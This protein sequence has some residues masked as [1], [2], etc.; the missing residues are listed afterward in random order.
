MRLG[1][2]CNFSHKHIGGSEAVLKYIS[3][4]LVKSYNYEV[5]VYSYSVQ[6][7]F[8]ENGVKYTSC[9]KGNDLITQINEND[10]IYVYSDSFWGWDT[11]VESIDKVAPAVSVALVG[12]YHMQSH[13]EIFNLL[14][15]NIDKFNLITHS[16]ITP[17]YKWCIDKGLPVKVI[18]NG[19]NIE[20]F[21]QNTINFREKYNIKEKY[22]ILNVGNYFYGKGF[23]LLPKICN[24]ISTFMHDFIILQI[25]NTVKYSYDKI[26]FERTKKQSGGMNIRFFRDISRED[27]IAAF[28]NADTFLFTSKKEVAP[29]VILE[30]IAAETPWL[31][32]DVGNIGEQKGGIILENEN[33]DRKGYKVVNDILLGK[34]AAN[35]G[36]IVRNKRTNKDLTDECRENIEKIDWDNIVPLYHEVFSK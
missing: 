32:M 22:V 18:P 9:K 27:V 23:E 34:Y 13:S 2:F 17:D 16:A 33:K 19:V 12:A 31:S 14:K 21:E 35:V 28:K 25:S 11:I 3:E 29:L 10:H 36:N 1:I 8:S 26:F 15:E 30:S 20:E 7:P 5:I 24:R 6:S 4:R